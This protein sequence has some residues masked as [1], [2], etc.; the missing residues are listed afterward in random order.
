M[1]DDEK[2]MYPNKRKV[3]IKTFVETDM[4]E[5]DKEVNKFRDEFETIAIQTNF[6]LDSKDT[7]Y[8]HYVVFYYEEAKQNR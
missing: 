2:M 8:Y 5:I 6:G 1:G 3:L 4:T 7:P